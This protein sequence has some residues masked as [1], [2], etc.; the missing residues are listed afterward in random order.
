M[1]TRGIH[2]DRM[3][4]T[5]C[6]RVCTKPGTYANLKQVLLHTCMLI[7]HEYS[8]EISVYDEGSR[9]VVH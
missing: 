6:P 1:Y 4:S 9:T 8:K 2:R 7:F 5:Y 3:R